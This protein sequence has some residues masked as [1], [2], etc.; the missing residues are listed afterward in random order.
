MQTTPKKLEGV[1]FYSPNGPPELFSK[2]LSSAYLL[3]FP[4]ALMLAASTRCLMSAHKTRVSITSFCNSLVL[5]YLFELEY[6]LNIVAVS[7]ML[8]HVR[9]HCFVADFRHSHVECI[10]VV[11]EKTVIHIAHLD[12]NLFGHR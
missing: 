11:F 12:V 4:H 7:G 3:H 9:T 2:Q 8:V 1:I 6:R 5:Y 10:R